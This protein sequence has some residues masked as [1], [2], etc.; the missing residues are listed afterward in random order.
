MN[1]RSTSSLKDIPITK[2]QLPPKTRLKPSSELSVIHQ[3]I[4]PDTQSK[5][6]ITPIDS[7]NLNNESPAIQAHVSDPTSTNIVVKDQPTMTDLVSSNQ[8]KIIQNNAD[9]DQSKAN[10]KVSA[11]SNEQ[12]SDDL[13]EKPSLLDFL[14]NHISL[15]YGTGDA[16]NWFIQLDSTFS[17]LKLSFRDRIEI[18]PYFLGGQAMIWYSLNRQKI[19]DYLDFCQLFTLEFLNVKA[20]H[21]TPGKNSM[22]NSMDHLSNATTPFIPHH[23]PSRDLNNPTSL[24]SLSSTISKALI[25]RFIKDPL[26]FYGNKDSVITW[27]DEIE[28][29]FQIMNLSDPDKLNLIHICL[30]SEAHQWFKQHPK[31][32]YSWS[33]FV[34]EIKNSFNSNL[35]RDIA[36]QKLQRYHQTIHQSAFQ[37]YNEM[38]K[39]IQQADPQMS[40]STKIHYLMNGLRSSLSIETRRNYPK[41]TQ[42]FLVQVKIAEDLTTLNTSFNNHAMI[43]ND[44]TSSNPIST[45]EFFDSSQHSTD[46]IYQHTNYNSNDDVDQPRYLNKI[47]DTSTCSSKPNRHPPTARSTN[48]PE[49]TPYPRP[50]LDPKNY[51]NNS[52]E[53]TLQ[54]CFKCGS[55]SH[56]ARNCSHFDKRDQ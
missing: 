6:Q 56:I 3:S 50:L 53:Q 34:S 11:D 27:L 20:S 45:N 7:S 16:Y 46:H 48:I 24:P 9:L 55:S 23:A 38:I 39:L 22:N 1:R 17:D 40:E 31:N 37:Y 5:Q 26:K 36:F 42:E 2:L 12:F 13:A 47:S 15:F 19:I 28:Q 49:S 29:Q 41:T 43:H 18:L 25:D 21:V 8:Q 30:K 35:Q 4:M 52:K 44:S 33:H 32:F 54:R 51:R 10:T 14:R